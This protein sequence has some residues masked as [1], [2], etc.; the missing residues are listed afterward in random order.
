M[1]YDC[2]TFLRKRNYSVYVFAENLTSVSCPTHGLM[3][4]AVATPDE[5]YNVINVS[6]RKP[7]KF[8]K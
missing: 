2:E 6:M 7:F 5:F 4:T 1:A 8:L 3:S